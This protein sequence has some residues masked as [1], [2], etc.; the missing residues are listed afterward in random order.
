MV[1]IA[2]GS[3]NPVKI[4]AARIGTARA[5]CISLEE[6]VVEGFDVPSGVSDQPMSDGETKRGAIDRCKNAFDAYIKKHGISPNF[7]VGL[8]GGVALTGDQDLEC[9]AWMV[10][11]NGFIFGKARTGAFV[12]P[13]IIKDLIVIDKLEL[14]EA[15]DRVF[16]TVNSKHKGGSVGQFTNGVIDRT[17]YYEHAIILAYIPFNYPQL[18]SV[19]NNDC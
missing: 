18:Y 10:V 12:L 13:P 7:A 15:D 17:A 16:K 4:S 2:V 5:L 3:K 9:F 11:Y 6:V 19:E 14:G 8:E 1:T